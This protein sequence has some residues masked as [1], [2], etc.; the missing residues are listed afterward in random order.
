MPTQD[1]HQNLQIANAQADARFWTVMSEVQAAQITGL[2]GTAEH[3]TA[4]AASAEPAAA[5]TAEKARAAA[6]RLAKA[7][8]GEAVGPVPPPMTR[9]DWLRALRW[10]EADAAHAER[11]AE[12][13]SCPLLRGGHLGRGLVPSISRRASRRNLAYA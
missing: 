13:D 1:D 4:A 7:E 3:A 10:T 12:I 8:R 5:E 6:A 9:A 2:R 11:L